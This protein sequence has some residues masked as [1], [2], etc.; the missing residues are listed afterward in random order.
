MKDI[1]LKVEIDGAI[2]DILIK[3]IDDMMEEMREYE[4]K[5]SEKMLERNKKIMALLDEEDIIIK[6]LIA[7]EEK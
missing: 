3:K 1:K 7:M 5:T 2:K 6:N 4:V